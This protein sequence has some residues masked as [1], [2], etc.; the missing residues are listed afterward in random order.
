MKQLHEIIEDIRL[1][2]FNQLVLVHFTGPHETTW[3]LEDCIVRF[4][5]RTEIGDRRLTIECSGVERFTLN[6]AGG[7]VTQIV[8]LAVDDWRDRGLEKIAWKVHDFEGGMMEVLCNQVR[9]RVDEG[10]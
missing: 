8:G 7:G 6:D 1:S 9:G 2:D 3:D 4:V 10:W 5:I